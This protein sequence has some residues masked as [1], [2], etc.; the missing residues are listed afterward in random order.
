MRRWLESLLEDPLLE[1]KMRFVAGPRQCGKTTL[2]REILARHHSEELLFDWDVP[3][4]RRLYRTD[5]LFYR[6]RIK[7]LAK[8]WMCFDEIHKQRKWKDILKGIYDADGGRVRLLVTGSARLELFRRAGDS[9]AG[10]FFLFRLPPTLLGELLGESPASVPSV[11]ARDWIDERLTAA[12]SRG[13]EDP[14]AAR[15]AT[16]HLLRFGPFPEPLLK[17][18]D[19]FHSLWRRNYLDSVI[20]GD[21]RDLTRLR[22][23]SLVEALVDLI[24]ARVGSPFSLNAVREDL[25]VAHATVRGMM[26]H[27]ERLLVV[28]ALSPY[29]KRVTRPVKRERKIYLFEWS[30]VEEEA[31]RFAK[32]N[33]VALELLA[34]TQFW[35]ENGPHE[36]VLH[37]LRSRDGKESDFLILRRRRPWCI[38]ECKLRKATVESHHR[39]FAAKLGGIPV[40]QVVRDHGVLE[41]RDREVVTV[42]ASRFLRA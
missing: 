4:T 11:D 32:K 27:L 38:V 31:A 42:S 24:P 21:L 30:S 2:A 36:W 20:R 25:E 29:A 6:S 18:T 19:R 40:V 34:R 35:T 28:F 5:T 12:P 17:G 41:A 22:D 15:G 23:L 8:P 7:A 39:L 16:E 33:F 13:T 37:Y 9:L 26:E 10:R 1:P 14:R 3:E